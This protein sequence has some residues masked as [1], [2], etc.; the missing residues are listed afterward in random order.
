MSGAYDYESIYRLH[1]SDSLQRLDNQGLFLITGGINAEFPR[2]VESV[3]QTKQLP[4]G[5]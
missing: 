4:G 3:L 1:L 5:G 2:H